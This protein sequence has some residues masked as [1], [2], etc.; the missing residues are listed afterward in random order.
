LT[1][2]LVSD[3]GRL[4]LAAKGVTQSASHPALHSMKG[5]DHREYYMRYSVEDLL[6][7]ARREHAALWG[8]MRKVI[9][10]RSKR[11]APA[12]IE[13]W[14]FDPRQIA[15]IDLAN[16]RSVRLSPD[17]QTLESRIRAGV[18]FCRG[19]RDEETMISH[20]VE[21]GLRHSEQMTLAARELELP[22]LRVTV[23]TTPEDLE[24]LE[25]LVIGTL[26]SVSAAASPRRSM[27]AHPS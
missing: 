5:L 17:R 27:P 12:V 1:L 7:M 16:V 23:Q 3:F 6:D 4:A 22:V 9:L 20:Y 8:G 26:N 21:R 13:G 10:A 15:K 25:S 19:A 14:Q 24:D 2:E 11:A 18:D